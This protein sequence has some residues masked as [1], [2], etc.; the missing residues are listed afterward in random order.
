VSF[1]KANSFDSVGFK[2]DENGIPI[3]IS[4]EDMRS[5]FPFTYDD[6]RIKAK[7]RYSNFK[8]GR[9]FNDLMKLIKQDCKIYHERKLDPSSSSSMIK[10]FYSSNIWKEIDKKYV[11]YK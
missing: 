10:G 8:Q 4:E 2:Y 5:R 11:K 7:S 1:T 6:V 3:T 9:D